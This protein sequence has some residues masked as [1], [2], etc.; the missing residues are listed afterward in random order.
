MLSPENL[1]A[2]EYE[3]CFHQQNK[4]QTLW[5]LSHQRVWSQTGQWPVPVKITVKTN[6]LSFFWV[7]YIKLDDQKAIYLNYFSFLPCGIAFSEIRFMMLPFSRV[8]RYFLL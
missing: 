4:T 2:T 7:F 1:I 5:A 8:N 6:K 3:S